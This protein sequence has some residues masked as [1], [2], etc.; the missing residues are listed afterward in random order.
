MR[1]SAVFATFCVISALTA[2]AGS[3]ATRR[4]QRDPQAPA[5]PRISVQARDAAA[6]TFLPTLDAVF[7]GSGL[8]I[9]T[10]PDAA[11]SALLVLSGDS[12]SAPQITYAGQDSESL[13][14][15]I[16]LGL[17]GSRMAS[18][19]GCRAARI[20]TVYLELGSASASPAS[21]MDAA[22]ALRAAL[23][24]LAAGNQ[25]TAPKAE[26]ISPTPGSTLSRS[27]VTFQWN[28]G[29]SATQYW[30][31]I[32]TWLGG[33]TLFSADQGL[34]TSAPVTGLPTD[35][36][37]IYVRLWSYVNGQWISND[38]QYKAYAP[39]GTSPAKAELTSPAPGST[40]PGASANFQWT[41]GTAVARYYLFVGLWQGGNTLAN[42]DAATNL[43]A[44]VTGLPTDGTT[45]YVRLWS[46]IDTAWQYNDYTV[47][48]NGS[49]VPA[50]AAM[51]S[52]APGSTLAGTTTTFQWSAG[53]G[54]LRYHLFVGKWQGGNTL[55]DQ[56]A[57]TN[58]S[59]VVS[60]LPNDGS[61]LYVRLWSYLAGE[62]QFNDYTYTASGSPGSPVKAVIT[63]PTP[64]STLTGPSATFVWSPGSNV[65]RYWL[66]VGT[67]QGNND[68]Y[69]ADQALNTTAT[70]GG[71]PTNGQVL[72][73]RLWSY[74]NGAWLSNDYSY[75]AAGQ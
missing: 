53:S 74:I 36:R 6:S 31:M 65:Q 25:R 73:V 15:A 10:E 33:D 32:G 5:A 42:I 60:G 62:W 21:L 69:G 35:G 59:A 17:P 4:P 20:P 9:V 7:A 61:T 11:A 50:K 38:Y 58:L 37:M 3:A 63:S 24:P 43:Q 12:S 28:P 45:L 70:V 56:S 30:L 26:M 57:D 71:L 39:A 46:F 29:D 49:F 67:S 18:C 54:V 27:A 51:S 55:Y 44:S 68:I 13:G 2:S 23:S 14:R 72:H 34:L 40:L 64:G 8:E 41:A 52:P 48:A 22:L 19:G 66:F 16:Q 75:R 47:K 1:I